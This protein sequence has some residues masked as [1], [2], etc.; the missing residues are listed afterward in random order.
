MQHS[1][2]P[3][4]SRRRRTTAVGGLL[5]EVLAPA[6]A[7][8]GILLAQL[9]PYW[10]SICPLLAAH[11]VPESVRAGTL[12]LATTTSSVQRELHF[13]APSIIEGVNAIL[14]YAAITSVK[15]MVRGETRGMA[16][17]PGKAPKLTAPLPPSRALTDKAAKACQTIN[18]DDL[19]TA[20]AKLGAVALK[21]S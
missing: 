11:A 9:L 19:R 5:R 17:A 13:L 7:K 15:A 6:A 1:T 8:Q 18:D 10:P 2:Q 12:T 16:G 4:I 20:L 14:G 3:E 21:G